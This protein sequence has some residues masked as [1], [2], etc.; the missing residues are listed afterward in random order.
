MRLL[1]STR[2]VSIL[3]ITLL[4]LPSLVLIHSSL[5]RV[6]LHNPQ[7]IYFVLKPGQTLSHVAHHLH[8]KHGLNFAKR[9]V[10]L[11]YLERVTTRIQA[12]EYQFPAHVQLGQIL[13]TLVY[14]NVVLHRFTLVEG[15]T[16]AQMLDA[17]A[18]QSHVFHTLQ[19]DGQ[20]LMAALHHPLQHPEGQF[21]PDT[22]L[23]AEGTRDI[24]LLQQAY[25]RMQLELQTEWIKRA[26]K[27]PYKRPY[28]ALIV[29][30]MIE[31]E[32]ALDSERP[33][34]AAV[35]AKRLQQ[36]MR[37]Q[38]DATVFYGLGPYAPNALTRADLRYPTTYN[39]YVYSGLVPT[40]IAMPSLSSL[41][42][43]LHPAATNA[44]YYVAKGDGSHVFS[45]TLQQ[46]QQAVDRYQ[47]K[48][49]S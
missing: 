33:L 30:S 28:Q 40:P 11:G 46:H 45:A 3:I 6:S 44:L 22:Y 1:R 13:D 48:R 36:K 18:K 27:L 17:I 7:P 37:L 10:L 43:A 23:F 41:S 29:A 19:G 20:A 35:I 15:W 47:S 9:L 49:N 24:D 34:V 14:G 42:A 4:S 26:P 16:L 32:A 39:T 12:G 25:Q 21:F 31:K 38:I 5:R 2:I 8:A